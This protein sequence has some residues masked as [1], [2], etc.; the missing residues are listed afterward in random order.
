MEVKMMGLQ[1]KIRSLCKKR[2]MSVTDLEKELG[3]GNGS[4]TKKGLTA[5]RSDRLL[6]V[7]KYFGVPM[8]YFVSEE[9][10]QPKDY[11]LNEETA[12]I[13]QKI[14]DD[15]ELKAL[16]DATPGA[17]PEQLQLTSKMLMEMKGTNPNG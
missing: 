3:F 5:I 13:A 17:T 6:A 15:P 1:E 4:L 2:G 7:A 10:H 16:F 14:F 8:E 11:Y 9:V 12:R